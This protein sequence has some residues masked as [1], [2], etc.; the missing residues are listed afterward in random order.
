MELTNRLTKTLLG[1]GLAVALGFALAAG[2]QALAQGSWETSTLSEVAAMPTAR[3]SPHVGAIGGLL[4]VAGGED[5]GGKTALEAYDPLFDSWTTLAAMLSPRYGGAAGVIDDKLYVVGGWSSISCCK[6]NT[7]QIYDPAVGSGGTWSLGPNVPTPIG[8]GTAGVIDRKLYVRDGFTNLFVVYDPD[9]TPPRWAWKAS[10]PNNYAAQASGVIDGK[11]YV[12][13]GATAANVV[14]DALDVYDPIADS[15]TS[16]TPMPTARSG[17]FG[18]VLDGKLY[19]A[20]GRDDTT[21]LNTVVV[22]DPIVDSWTSLTPMPTARHG[23]HGGISSPAI[24]GKLYM[25]GG[26]AGATI[27]ATL[28]VFSPIVPPE[29]ATHNLIDDVQSLV[30]TGTLTADQGDGATAK[31]E[32]AI[33]SLYKGNTNATCGQLRA[34]INQINAFINDGTLTSTEGQDLIDAADNMRNELGC[35]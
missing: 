9:T 5:G 29:Q 14:K 1:A 15:W 19:V 32:A 3:N 6:T 31:L 28:E 2:N 4:Y 35:R 30:D 7:L 8:H 18:G 33:A 11:F 10:A 27:L 13:G 12:A 25:V 22:Y 21:E 24:D 34:L 23:G 20:G 26:Q 17:A 16:L